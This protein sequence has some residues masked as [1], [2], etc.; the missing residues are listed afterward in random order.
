MNGRRNISAF[1]VLLLLLTLFALPGRVFAAS[2]TIAV[3]PF[4]AQGTSFHLGAT[5]GDII[6]TSLAGNRDITLVERSRLTEVARQ[7]RLA[8]SGVVETATAAKAGKLVGARYFI[9]GAVSRFGALLVATARLVDVESGRV[10]ASFERTSKQGEDETTLVSRTLASDILAFISGDAPAPGDPTSDYKYYLYEAL[11]Y[12]NLGEYRKSL[13]FWEKMTQLSPRNGLL[14]FIVAGLHFQTKRYSDA[15]LAA[16]QAVTWEPSFAEAHLLVGKA[17]FLLG[18]NHKA[19][20]PLDKAL[21]L[22]PRLVEALFLKG[23]AFKNRKR[24][25]E[26]A[27][28]FLEAIQ[29]DQTYIPA[30]LALG[31]LLLENGAA[32]EAAGILLSG[33]RHQPANGNLRFLLGAAQIMRGNLQGAKEQLSALKTIDAA[34]AKKLEEMTLKK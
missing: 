15:L 28:Y 10:L 31:Q 30:Y 5:V 26:A 1:S 13:P 12:Y 2:M 25:E 7:Q 8:M 34:L 18:D 4:L 16:Q 19:T 27:D 14:R 22:D 23:S 20:P 29:I 3:H 17:Y 24:V 33:L 11:G 9:L 6:S 32:D 21:E